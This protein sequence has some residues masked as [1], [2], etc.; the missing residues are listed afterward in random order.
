MD[1]EETRAFVCPCAYTGAIEDTY[2]SVLALGA[3]GVRTTM[4]E[5]T[6]SSTGVVANTSSYCAL[7]RRITPSLNQARSLQEN[8]MQLKRQRAYFVACAQFIGSWPKQTRGSRQRGRKSK[9]AGSLEDDA[10]SASIDLSVLPARPL[11]SAIS[12]VCP[13]RR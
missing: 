3:G 10:G 1:A 5:L 7:C 4:Q 2:A 9:N 13:N 11:A 12:R 6:A 8:A